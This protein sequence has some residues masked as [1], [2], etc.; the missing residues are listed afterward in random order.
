MIPN[1]TAQER[2]VSRSQHLLVTMD[3]FSDEYSFE[4]LPSTGTRSAGDPKVKAA[5][6]Q[7]LEDGWFFGKLLDVKSKPRM[8]RCYS[9]PSSRF[10]QKILAN[11]CP[12]AGKSST[13]RELLTRGNLTRAPSL[14]PNIGRSEEKIHETERYTSG[15]GMSRQ[16]TRQLSDQILIQKPT[17]VRKKEGISHEKTANH[18]TGNYRR[19]KMV[20]EG[21]SSRHGLIRTPSL[22][23]YIWREETNEE[24]DSDEITMSKLIRQA[25][26]LSSDI[27]PRQHSSKMILPRY[28]PPRNS[29][30]VESGGDALHNI[31]SEARHSNFPKNQMSKLEKSLSNPEVHEVIRDK[32]G[33]NPASMVEIFAGLQEKKLYIKRNQDL[34]SNSWQGSS[35]AS[36]APIPVWVSKDSSQDMKAQLKFWARSVASNVR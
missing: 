27:L 10:D 6:H 25:M 11:S 22:P 8:L 9:D 30:E 23:P 17:S 36:A 20:A 35:C 15:T 33:L 26:P 19:S 12:P 3:N 18:A 2:W 24:S 21:Q 13:T 4:P 29:S 5:V 1:T 34:V 14:P 32:K 31:S 28:R 7:L 16:L